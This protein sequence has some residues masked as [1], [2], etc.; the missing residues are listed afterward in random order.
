[1]LAPVHTFLGFVAPAPP[2]SAPW[3]RPGRSQVDLRA[4]GGARGGGPDIDGWIAEVTGGGGDLPQGAMKEYNMK[5]FWPTADP[6][7]RTTGRSSRS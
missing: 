4:S 7:R 3:Q 6:A 2:M 1:M 5:W